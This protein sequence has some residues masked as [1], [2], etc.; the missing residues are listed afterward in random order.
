M[1]KL[2][3]K[4]GDKKILYI[5]VALF[6]IFASLKISLAYGAAYGSHIVNAS[7]ISTLGNPGLAANETFV[8]DEWSRKI[9]LDA[10]GGV[11]GSD[12]YSIFN[13]QSK[14]I[15]QVAFNLPANATDISV[16]DAYGDY[17]KTGIATFPGK[18]YIQ[19]SIT[20]REP[21]KPK[22][23]NEF[24]IT[25]GLPS[26]KFI[27]QKSWQN[28]MLRLNLVKPE[29][30]IVKKFSL[31]ISLPEGAE[32]RNFSNTHYKVERQGLSLKI[33]LTEYNLVEFHT[34][35]ITLEYQYFILWRI[36]RPLIWTAVAAL[37]G[38][39]LFF[40]K[41]FLHP[42]TV[43]TPVSPSILKK[44]VEVYEEKRRLS[45]EIQSLQKL[46]RSGK[47]SRRRLRL[48]KRSLDQRLA[49]LNKRLA[50]LKDQII[51]VADRYNEMLRELETAE[52]E[53]ETLNMDIERVEV[54]FRRGEISAEVRRRL[55]DEYSRIKSRAEG[56]ISE[57]LLR[58]QEENV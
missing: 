16:Q 56:K 32:L 2:D 21:L 14:V 28:Y 30:W 12:Y 31:I 7:L 42:T 35:H 24:L 58:L 11:S 48:R 34:S 38:T 40:I 25:Y 19:T 47:L 8:I 33:I 29:N 46:F 10:W 44:F 5:S 27:S 17:P 18:D 9:S 23:R 55:M 54:R 45:E 1:I 13:N 20:L 36:F 43:V 51:N 6:L 4:R 50:E 53:I 26:S 41:R 22:E 49:V 52:V 57:I 3:R 37:A 39:A 15:Y